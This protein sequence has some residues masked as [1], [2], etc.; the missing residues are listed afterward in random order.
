M[1]GLAKL[2]YAARSS[3][4]S[5]DG[6]SIKTGDLSIGVE[7][8]SLRHVDCSLHKHK[9]QYDTRMQ[10]PGSINAIR[11]QSMLHWYLEADCAYCSSSCSS[12]P[13]LLWQLLQNPATTAGIHNLA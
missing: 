9:V 12:V 10:P 8:C 5:K 4:C 7:T 2:L 6:I 3:C 13:V 11:Q 1:H